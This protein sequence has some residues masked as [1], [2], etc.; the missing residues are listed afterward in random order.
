M[1]EQMDHPKVYY[2]IPDGGEAV[3]GYCDIKFRLK[4]DEDK[5]NE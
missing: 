4:K 2:T 5:F 1:G 3:C